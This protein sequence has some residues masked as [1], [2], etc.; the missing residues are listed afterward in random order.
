MADGAFLPDRAVAKKMDAV[1]AA[2]ACAEDK[3]RIRCAETRVYIIWYGPDRI[4]A[5]YRFVS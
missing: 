1:P 2:F 4:D 5:G 3:Q